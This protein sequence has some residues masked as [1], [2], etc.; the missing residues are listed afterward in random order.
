MMKFNIFDSLLRR[1]LFV[2]RPGRC[3]P[4]Q[5]CDGPD[6]L[7]SITVTVALQRTSQGRRVFCGSLSNIPARYREVAG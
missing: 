6:L 1:S 4:N 5:V 2:V 3:A 7:K